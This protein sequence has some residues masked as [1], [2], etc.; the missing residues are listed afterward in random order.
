MS[1]WAEKYPS[2]AL[3]LQVCMSLDEVLTRQKVDAYKK[4]KLDDAPPPDVVAR[5]PEGSPPKRFVITGSSAAAAPLTRTNIS[6]IASM[7][8][9]LDTLPVA[10]TTSPALYIDMLAMQT[11]REHICWDRSTPENRV[12]QGGLL[13][14]E[15]VDG[16][17]RQTTAVVTDTL[18]A[19]GTRGSAAYVKFDHHIWLRMF[20]EFDRLVQS[21][22]IK[23]N[24]KI[25]GWYHT[26]PNMNV[27][28]S[29]TDMGTQRAIFGQPWN[30][31]LVLNPQQRLC[32]CFRGEAATPAPLVQVQL[33]AR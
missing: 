15:I 30:Y 28:M 8:D 14:G 23:Q 4:P 1:E 26:H 17:S 19:L 16:P 3:A 29:G 12:E 10:Q 32:A 11:M 33:N 31:A 27:F 18:R 21:G 13:V 6:D 22:R 20:D 9:R 7:G 24:R 2:V 25:I 5:R